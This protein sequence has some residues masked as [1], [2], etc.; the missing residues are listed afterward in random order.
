M[1]RAGVSGRRHAGRHPVREAW[2]KV[3]R[4]LL[5]SPSAA[6]TPSGRT[7]VGAAS[8]AHRLSSAAPHAQ[9]AQALTRGSHFLPRNL[10]YNPVLLCVKPSA[11]DRGQGGVHLVEVSLG[12]IDGH[13]RRNSLILDDQRHRHDDLFY[14]GRGTT[15]KTRYEPL[16]SHA[17]NLERVDRG[18]LGHAVDTVGVEADVPDIVLE[19]ILPLGH[20]GDDLDGQSAHGVRADDHGWT[21]L[22]NLGAHARSEVDVPYLAARRPRSRTDVN[23]QGR[24]RHRDRATPYRARSA[25]RSRRP[26]RQGRA[27]ARPRAVSPALGVASH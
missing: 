14:D 9:P 25:R 20:R 24:R 23:I 1:W 8:C 13:P 21:D 17:L 7:A 22:S 16:D 4:A 10:D 11:S 18:D 3:K 6:H 15:T 12:V 2:G 26:V 27:G 5:S 19:V